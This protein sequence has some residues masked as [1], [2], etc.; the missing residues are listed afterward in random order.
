[1]GHSGFSK[2]QNVPFYPVPFYPTFVP[3]ETRLTESLEL[4]LVWWADFR[5]LVG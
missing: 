1:M 5:V 3:L 2:N 4:Q